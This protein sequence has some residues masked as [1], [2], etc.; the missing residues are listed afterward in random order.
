MDFVSRHIGP[1]A[2]EQEHMLATLG[3]ASLDELTTAALPAY[4]KSTL[5]GVACRM[6]IQLSKLRGVIL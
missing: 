3:Y 6:R 2:A 4:R 1:S 5:P